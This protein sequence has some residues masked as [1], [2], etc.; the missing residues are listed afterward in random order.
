MTTLPILEFYH[1]NSKKT[2]PKPKKLDHE[3]FRD[4]DV[5]YSWLPWVHVHVV[6]FVMIYFTI[7]L[8]L[9]E[10]TKYI[11]ITLNSWKN[12]W[13]NNIILSFRFCKMNKRNSTNLN[14][15]IL[16]NYVYWSNLMIIV[17]YNYYMKV[18]PYYKCN[19][20]HPL[21]PWKV[22]IILIRNLRLNKLS[23]HT[24]IYMNQSMYLNTMHATFHIICLY[25]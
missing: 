14:K 8:V 4:L 19:W 10:G 3:L 24:I 6:W 22:V 12:I 5:T 9:R 17:L 21:Y 16:D 20:L 15:V 18:N 1:I 13:A 7:D 2:K 23:T 25:T 11:K